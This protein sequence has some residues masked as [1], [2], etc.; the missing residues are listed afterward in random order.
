MA[1]GQIDPAHLS[2]EALR[3]WYQRSPADVEKERQAAAAQRYASFF[4]GL[5][6]NAATSASSSFHPENSVS[7]SAM[8]QTF[9]AAAPP[10]RF[11]PTPGNCVSC[12]GLLPPPPLPPPFGTFPFPARSIPSRRDL[13]GRAPGGGGKDK[14]HCEA[15]ERDD[16]ATCAEQPTAQAKAVCY[17]NVP[18]RR[19]NCDTS[20]KLGDPPLFRVKRRSG[21]PWR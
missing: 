20:D 8:R 19:Y 21:E 13:P 1:Y 11:K 15:Q 2:G 3:R 12:H 18:K 6:P 5:R 16:L 10:D 14:S 4:G 9:G 17:E 7:R